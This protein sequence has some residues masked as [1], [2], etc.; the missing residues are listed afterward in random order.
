[1]FNTQS[2]APAHFGHAIMKLAH[3]H[4]AGPVSLLHCHIHLFLVFIF[5]RK[6]ARGE[7]KDKKNHRDLNIY[8][9]DHLSNLCFI[10]QLSKE[11]QFR[12]ALSPVWSLC[13][14]L[15]LSSSEEEKRHYLNELHET[16]RL[17]YGL[18]LICIIHYI[19]DPIKMLK[20]MT[21]SV[22]SRVGVWR[23]SCFI[24]L[25]FCV[26]RHNMEEE[27]RKIKVGLKA[28]HGKYPVNKKREHVSSLRWLYFGVTQTLTA[29]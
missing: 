8:L 4:G 1:M 5:N 13:G 12:N 21:I 22:H 29:L 17:L 24:K 9:F 10:G 7:K 16:L 26:N 2:S 18:R 20:L 11:V 28:R 14:R 27:D 6:E 19:N 3:T 25:I 15:R 23:R